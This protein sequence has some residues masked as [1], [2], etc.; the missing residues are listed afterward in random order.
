MEC[1]DSEQAWGFVRDTA[2]DSCLLGF[3]LRIQGGQVIRHK[4]ERLMTAG[5]WSSV[6]FPSLR[7]SVPR[8]GAAL[9]LSL[10]LG[11]ICP[12][13]LHQGSVCLCA[14]N[15]LPCFEDVK[16][17]A[18]NIQVSVRVVSALAPGHSHNPS[19]IWRSPTE[20]ITP[21]QILKL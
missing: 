8:L 4:W 20:G 13:I 2:H 3:L 1:C 17:W 19:W 18:A 7:K 15:L 21:F 11:S 12:F 16:T 10:R 6:L 14:L 5:R 9:H